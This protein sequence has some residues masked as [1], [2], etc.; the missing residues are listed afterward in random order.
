M[1]SFPHRRRR[2]LAASLAAE[3]RRRAPETPGVTPVSRRSHLTITETGGCIIRGPGAG[4]DTLPPTMAWV[5]TGPLWPRCPAITDITWTRASCPPHSPGPTLTPWTFTGKSLISSE[6]K[7]LKVS[8]RVAASSLTDCVDLK[9]DNDSNN[10][11]A[12]LSFCIGLS[13]F[14]Q[15]HHSEL[16]NTVLCIQNC[17][18]IREI[19]TK[20]C[21]CFLAIVMQCKTEILKINTYPSF[22]KPI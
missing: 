21:L 3:T 2:L 8:P 9:S 20:L 18:E 11:E 6:D 7:I 22:L 16:L 17:C 13:V 15:Q 4:A 12:Q 19:L 10:N 1:T 14:A 5:T